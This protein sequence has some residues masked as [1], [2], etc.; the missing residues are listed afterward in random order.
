M[1]NTVE[2][3]HAFL[4]AALDLGVG[5]FEIAGAVG[6]LLDGLTDLRLLAGAEPAGFAFRRPATLEL[7]WGPN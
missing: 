6:L 4:K 2:Q 5:L 7:A 3:L 1:R